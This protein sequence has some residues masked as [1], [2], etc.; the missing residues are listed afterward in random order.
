MSKINFRDMEWI[1]VLF[2]TAIGAGVLFL[3]LQASISGIVPLTIAAILIFP[4]IYYAERN[5]TEFVLDEKENLD[6]TEAFNKQLEQK[7]A[8]ISTIIYFLSCYTV[9]IAYATSLPHTVSGALN[10]YKI[11]DLHLASRPWFSFIVLIIPV[12]IMMAKRELMLKIISI[13]IYPLIICILVISLY[14]IPYWSFS[15]LHIGDITFFGIISGL[16]TVFP[17]LVFSMNYCQSLSQMVFYYKAHSTNR[18]IAKNKVEKNVYLGTILIVTFTLFF[19][20]SSILS[21]PA[22]KIKDAIAENVSILTLISSIYQAG[23]LHYIGPAIAIT[24]ILSSFLGVFLGT[25]EAC[26]GIITQIL[27]LLNIKTKLSHKT[28]EKISFCF[29]FISLWMVAVFDLKILAILG[30]FTAPSIATL[31]FILRAVLRLKYKKNT[32]RE[33]ILQYIF[34]CIGLFVIFGYAIGTV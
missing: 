24:A 31:I 7:F 21:V 30:L 6:I 1:L 10:L 20:Y 16:L 26:D 17:I 28:I 29:I 12:L 5:L 11:T 18:E 23:I 15:N 32:T 9:I 34:I 25:L 27:K 3:P 4:I 2:G 13:I 19:I 22:D 14:L 33:K 8:I